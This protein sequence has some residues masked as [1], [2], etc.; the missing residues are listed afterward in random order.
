M[1]SYKY[2][3]HNPVI[4]KRLFIYV[5]IY[6]LSLAREVGI[7]WLLIVEGFKTDATLV[8]QQVLLNVVQF[9]LM[10]DCHSRLAYVFCFLRKVQSKERGKE[11]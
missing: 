5:S 1:L 6:L 11:I 9:S 8:R 7:S 3:F 2:W 10:L 4:Y